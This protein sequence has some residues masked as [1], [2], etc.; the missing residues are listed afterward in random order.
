MT[1]DASEP[2]ELKKKALDLY[3]ELTK[4]VITL[5]VVV[6][7]SF[8][9]GLRLFDLSKV[10]VNYQVVGGLVLLF[11]S[12]AVGLLGYGRLIGLS[13]KDVYDLNDKTLL[14]F[15]KIQQGAFFVGT[16]LLAAWMVSPPNGSNAPTNTDDA[17]VQSERG[18][19]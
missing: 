14:W 2:G 15:G 7:G 13:K 18:A 16:A 4:Q 10:A 11:L 17:K 12:V 1:D 5:C 6:I 19:G 9:A 8:V 3:A